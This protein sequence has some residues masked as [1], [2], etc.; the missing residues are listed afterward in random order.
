MPIAL[1]NI[2]GK[3][4]LPWDRPLSLLQAK[5]HC[6]SLPLM[7]NV[8]HHP[9]PLSSIWIVGIV[10]TNFNREQDIDIAIDLFK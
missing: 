10:N 2:S 8:L 4:L 5:T 1:N 7:F 9:S 6:Y 3:I